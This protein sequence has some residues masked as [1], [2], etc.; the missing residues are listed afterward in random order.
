MPTWE[1]LPFSIQSANARH[2]WGVAFN[3]STGEFTGKWAGNRV[4]KWVDEGFYGGRLVDVH[5]AVNFEE[6]RQLLT[7]VVKT[8]LAGRSS[9]RLFTSDDYVVAGERIVLP[10]A[11]DGKTGD[12]ILGASDYVPPP[13]L[14]QLTMIHENVEWYTF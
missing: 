13:L 6:C 4:S 11:V 10:L 8:P 7:K 1:D 2:L 5:A 12:G 14:G 3:P 9:G